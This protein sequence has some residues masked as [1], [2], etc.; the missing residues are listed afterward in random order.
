M[1]TTRTHGHFGASIP[2]IGA[3]AALADTNRGHNRTTGWDWGQITINTT[4]GVS[5]SGGDASSIDAPNGAHSAPQPY[6]L[7][8]LSTNPWTTEIVHVT[9]PALFP[10]LYQV[11]VIKTHL[12]AILGSLVRSGRR[13]GVPHHKP[14][15]TR[16]ASFRS[17]PSVERSCP[18][19]GPVGLMGDACPMLE[20]RAAQRSYPEDSYAP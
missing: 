6:D 8:G 3:L 1:K 9:E 2:F 14:H 12:T 10:G 15:A 11:S 19:E 4:T 16:R 5:I 17:W 13:H 20:H 18:P 7:S